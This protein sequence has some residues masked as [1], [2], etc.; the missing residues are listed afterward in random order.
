MSLCV[1]VSGC[2]DVNEALLVTCE[3]LKLHF[4][5]PK[6]QFLEFLLY[7]ESYDDFIVKNKEN[8]EFMTETCCTI[9][10]QPLVNHKK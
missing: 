3:S 8:R 6:D 4:L 9:H 5:Q 1:S 10:S 7:L 2:Y